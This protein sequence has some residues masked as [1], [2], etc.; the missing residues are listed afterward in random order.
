MAQRYKFESKS[1]PLKRQKGCLLVVSNGSKIQ[2]WK[3]ITTASGSLLSCGMLFL[4]AQSSGSLLSC[5]MLFL[6]AQRYKFES[7]SQLVVRYVLYFQVVSNG[8]KIQIWKQITTRGSGLQE[9]NRLFLMAQRYKFESKSQRTVA[10]KS[11]IS[12]CF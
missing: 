4:M 7:K 10:Q 11:S 2:I 3:Q 12:R 8:S 9:T 1:Q 5:G 6:M